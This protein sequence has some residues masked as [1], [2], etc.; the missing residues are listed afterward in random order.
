MHVLNTLGS[1][2]FVLFIAW[3]IL[4]FNTPGDHPC[5]SSE[6][7]NYIESSIELQLHSSKVTKLIHLPM[8]YIMLW[9]CIQTLP[10]PWKAILTSPAVL[11]LIISHFA[12]TWGFYTLLM[13][14]P[15]YLDQT[16]CVDI[17]KVGF[18]LILC[19]N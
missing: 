3:L 1:F 16:L 18:F 14:L 4:A 8:L 19:C 6:E 12:Y 2:G 9:I 15:M 7:K 17:T 10:I 11:G 13:F 5:I